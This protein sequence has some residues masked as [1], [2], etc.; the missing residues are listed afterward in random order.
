MDNKILIVIPVMNLWDRYT[1]HCME[2]IYA[3]KCEVPFEV[4]IVDNASVDKTVECA[5]DFGNRKMP[6]RVHVIH[7]DTNKGCA[8]G[9]NQGVQFGIDNGFTHFLVINNDILL[10][11][12]TIQHLFNRISGSDK[13][14]VSAVDV[15]REVSTPQAVLNGD[16][17]I[18]KKETSE[19][20][21]PNFSCFMISLETIERV[22]MFEEIYYPAYW[23]DNSYHYRLKV[24]GGPESA[25]ASLPA[26][27]YHYG[28]RTQNEGDPNKKPV[29]MGSAFERNRDRYIDLWGGL[30]GAER[31][32]NPRNDKSLSPYLSRDQQYGKIG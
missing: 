1:I 5:T 26:I 8:A 16:D 6:G 15:S 28:S 2:S 23:E 21:H 4:V 25:I 30:P 22:G 11:P 27:F 17:P 7:N 9:W 31:F 14:L 3:S 29:V 20:P 13:L 24:I 32:V 19:A 18:N 12:F 10:S